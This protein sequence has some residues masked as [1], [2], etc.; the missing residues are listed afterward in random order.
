MTSWVRIDDE[1]RC[2][3]ELA[4]S[5]QDL[6]IEH[7]LHQLR[8]A[9]ARPFGL[10]HPIDLRIRGKEFILRFPPGAL[11]AQE[12]VVTPAAFRHQVMRPLLET[13]V[14]C[15]DKGISGLSSLGVVGGRWIPPMEWFLPPP[16]SEHLLETDVDVKV[17]HAWLRN[18]PLAKRAGSDVASIIDALAEGDITRLRGLLAAA[19]VDPVDRAPPSFLSLLTEGELL[20]RARNVLRYRRIPDAAVADIG[21]DPRTHIV[22]EIDRGFR[23]PCFPEMQSPS[24]QEIWDALIDESKVVPSL[25]ASKSLPNALDARI[26]EEDLLLRWIGAHEDQPYLYVSPPTG[27]LP[28]K[29]YV[30]LHLAGDDTLMKRKRELTRF[31]GSHP[32]LTPLL[33]SPPPQRPFERNGRSREDLEEAIL[34]ARG[35]FAVQGPPGTGKTHLATEVVRHFLSKTPGGRVLI[36]AK[37]HFALEHILRKITRALERDGVEHRAYRS[38]SLARL[39]RNRG[40]IDRTWLGTTLSRDLGARK[41]APWAEGWV[42]W[43]ANTSDQHDQ[44]LV[45]LCQQAANLFFATTMDAAMVE[46]AGSE[47]FDLVVVEEAGKCYPSE[48]LHAL[49]LGRTAL[50]IGDQRQLPPYQEKNTREGAE[51]WR[52]AIG[53]ALRDDEQRSVIIDR[54]GALFLGMEALAKERGPLTET[55]KAWLRPFEFLFDRLTSRHRLEEQFRMEAPLS[56]VIGSVFY[57][58][59]FIHRKPELTDRGIIE[60]RPLSDTLPPDFDVPLLWIDTPHCIEEPQ[61]TEDQSKRGVRDNRYEHDIILRYLRRLRPGRPI[62]FVILTPYRAQKQLFLGSKELREV[63]KALSEEPFERV[64]RTTDEY[65]GREAEL[66]VL[67][68]VRNNSLGAR[69]WGFMTEPERVNVMF[70]RARFRQVV[71]GCGAHIERHK[72]EC[73]WL[74]RVFQA[75]KSEARDCR[76]ARVVK[77]RELAH[78]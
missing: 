76:S 12:P 77:A 6:A 20:E 26:S 18:H 74:Y 41:W 45:S 13:L 53:R 73:Q 75:Y 51:M 65:Q 11:D 28:S 54:F 40:E 29:G 70:S 38:V 21:L 67:S 46:L 71:V 4:A 64:V 30:R 3:I 14:L 35:L 16:P 47:S 56:R 57:D 34:A 52:N 78:G 33:S 68:L 60:A 22:L 55:E 69:A 5:C 36:C 61:A 42:E 1:L 32:A 72:S 17:A 59:P 66:T 7:A 50:M 48:L 9:R 25:L 31:A 39:R 37:E 49:C 58:R 43:Q 44:R 24:P 27:P 15:H 2:R 23:D 63:C 19:C 62:D 8:R 10:V